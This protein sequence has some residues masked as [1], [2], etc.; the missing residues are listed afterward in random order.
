VLL[1][2]LAERGARV[3]CGDRHRGDVELVAGDAVAEQR[4]HVVGI[5]PQRTG[6]RAGRWRRGVRLHHAEQ[7]ADESGRRPVDEADPA[8]GAHDAD[9]FVGAPAVVGREHHADAR[10][11]DVEIVVV[12][13]EVLGIRGAP[14]DAEVSV[15][16]L[17]R[18][19]QLR[20]Q[21][22]GDDVGAGACRGN[23][24]VPRPGGDVEDLLPSADVQCVDE[25]PA[26]WGDQIGDGRIV[27]RCPQA[28]VPCLDL[29]V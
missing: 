11:G 7:L 18:L 23:R 13:R 10:R 6:L 24:D 4:S 29:G 25:S 14:G 15:A 26:Q 5:A 17:A 2:E 21:V 20:G 28:A 9:E 12:E 3:E 16:C 22:A 1:E 19:E 27:A 8:T